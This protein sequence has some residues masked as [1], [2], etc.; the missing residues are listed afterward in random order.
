MDLWIINALGS[1]VLFL[2]WLGGQASQ[3]GQGVLQLST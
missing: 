2:L 1:E 3:G